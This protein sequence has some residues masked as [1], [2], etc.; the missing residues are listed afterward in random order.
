MSPI[1]LLSQALG[2]G[3]FLKVQLDKETTMTVNFE[4]STFFRCVTSRARDDCLF[5]VT[6]WMELLL[7]HKLDIC[8]TRY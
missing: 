4:G 1:A 3:V 7:R 5:D 8:A 6:A 2:L